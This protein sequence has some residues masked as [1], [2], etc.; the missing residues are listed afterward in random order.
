[1]M[2]L[3]SSS[4]RFVMVAVICILFMNYA[5]VAQDKEIVRIANENY[6]K[7]VMAY[8]ADKWTEA[9]QYFIKS[10]ETFP[11][12]I[13][14]YYLSC[15]YLKLEKSR[16]AL[17]FA[18]KALNGNPQ[19]AEPYR[20]G[21]KEIETWAKTSLGASERAKSDSPRIRIRGKLKPKHAKPR[22]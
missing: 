3:N 13:K 22:N 19:L 5:V 8:Y 12:P 18:Q 2:K 11:T 15:I 6:Q 17:V 20:T 14:D 1:M 9:E 10:N 16:E 21:A 4:I 7:G